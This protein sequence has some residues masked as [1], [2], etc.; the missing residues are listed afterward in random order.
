MI[1]SATRHSAAEV[2]REVTGRP[3]RPSGLRRAL[4]RAPIWLYRLRMAP[5][6]GRRFVLINHV[7]RVSGRV[8]QAVVEVVALDNANGAITVASGFGDRSDWYLNVLAHPAITVQLGS[9]RLS[10]IAHRLSP[11]EAAD[12]MAHY[13]G[14]H[15]LAGRELCRFMGMRVDGSAVD[16]R[17]AGRRIP[18]LR[19]SR[20]GGDTAPS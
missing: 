10:V 19:L 20:A 3:A 14:R 5:L 12:T 2:S 13:A 17:A 6:L 18:M 15:P 9:R 16:F 11:D 1:L 8:R 4:F 7:G